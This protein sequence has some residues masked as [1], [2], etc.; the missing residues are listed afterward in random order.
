MPRGTNAPNDWPAEPVN[1]RS[2]VS[3]GS[4][5]PAY[6]LVTS[7]PSIVPTVRFTLRTARLARTGSPRSRASSASAISSLSSALSRP[8]SCG[9]GAA[10]VLVGEDVPVRRPVQDRGQVQAAGLPVVDRLGDVERVGPPDRLLEGAEAQLRKEL[11]DLL[12][13][14]LE[15]A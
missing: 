10:R 8:W 5:A 15:E 4:P 9:L 3:S 14:V 6:L 13:D 2:M 1:V 11:A 7:W 12:G